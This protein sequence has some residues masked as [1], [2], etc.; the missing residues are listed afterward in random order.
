MLDPGMAM[1]E[2]DR[3]YTIVNN[4]DAYPS[5]VDYLKALALK[6]KALVPNRKK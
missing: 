5:I 2:D 6:P 1:K 4:F 3:I